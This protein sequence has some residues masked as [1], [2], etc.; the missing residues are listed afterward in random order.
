EPADGNGL[1]NVL[2]LSKKMTASKDP[3]KILEWLKI[4]MVTGNNVLIEVQKWLIAS[5]GCH[6]FNEI[7][8]GSV[9]TLTVQ[10]E[11]R[12]STPP[13]RVRVPT[14]IATSKSRPSQPVMRVVSGISDSNSSG[15]DIDGVTITVGTD[16]DLPEL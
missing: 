10:V 8:N 16:D 6:S 1:I 13:T 9:D 3:E 14:P 15:D 11:Q 2:N 7:V 4:W 12:R 5:E